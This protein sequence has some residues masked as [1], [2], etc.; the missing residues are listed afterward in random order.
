MLLCNNINEVD[1]NFIEENSEIFSADC[2]SCNNMEEAE[3][4][5][6]CNGNGSHDLEPYQY[7]LAD[8]T[9]WDKERFINYRVPFGYSNALELNVIPIYDYGTSWSAFSYSR[10]VEDDYVLSFDET[11]ERTTPY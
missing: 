8:L 5:E 11:L 9:D 6:D 3:K 4:C 1:E 7:F 2:E 10:E